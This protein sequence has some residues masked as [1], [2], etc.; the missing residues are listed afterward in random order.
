MPDLI[1]TDLVRLDVDLGTDKND[2]IRALAGVV[3]EAGRADDVDRLVADTLA[4]EDMAPTGLPG[5]MAIPH[6]RSGAVSEPTLVFARLDPAVD[7]GASDGAADLVFLIAGPDTGDH[8][9]QILTRLTRALVKPAFTDVLR[10]VRS[11]DTA[12]DHVGHALGLPTG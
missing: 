10:S 11:V 9:L 6:C 7:F 5:G 8:H 3:A 1:T 4:R 12:V 2:V